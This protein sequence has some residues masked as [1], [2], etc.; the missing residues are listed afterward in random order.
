MGKLLFLGTG[1]SLGVP[2][3]GC[4]CKV[5]QSKDPCNHRYRPSAFVTFKNKKLL[6][7]AGPDL[8]DQ[9]LKYNIT[10]IDGLILTHIHYDHIGGLDELRAFNFISKK[11]VPCLLSKASKKD[12]VQRHYHMFHSNDECLKTSQLDLQVLEE[13]FGKT[14]F[15]DLPITYVSYKQGAIPVNGYRFGNLAYLT[16]IKSYDEK[17]FSYLKGVKKLVI[18]ALKEEESKAHL[19]FEEAIAFAKKIGVEVAYFTHIAH[20]VDHEKVSQKLP[21]GFEIAYDGLEIEFDD[22]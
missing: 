14:T 8:R 21:K 20:E 18:S 5:C 16:D 7:D 17:I 22:N 6:L 19:T 3:I 10:S 1:S 12:I 11:A 15:L 9:A 2:V 4:K 13:E